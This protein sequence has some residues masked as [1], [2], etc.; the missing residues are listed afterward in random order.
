MAFVALVGASLW[1]V[2]YFFNVHWRSTADSYV[3]PGA[4]ALIAGDLGQIRDGMLVGGVFDDTVDAIADFAAKNGITGVTASATT[5]RAIH[6]HLMDRLATAR[7]RAVVWDYYFR[8]PRPEDTRLAAGVRRLEDAGVPVILAALSFGPDGSPDLS[9]GVVGPLGDRLRQGAIVAR[10]MVKRP[11]EFVMAIKRGEQTVVP[12]VAT[13][14]LASILHPAARVE[15]EWVGRRPSIDLL[16]EVQPGAYMRQRD[17]IEL[18]KVVRMRQAEPPVL[19]DD[20]LAFN[21]FHLER[22]EG[23]QRRTVPYQTLL[24]CPDDELSNLVA[25]KLLVIGDLRSPHL[26]FVGDRHRVKYGVAVVDDVPGCYLLADAIAGSLDRYWVKSAYLLPPTM[27][28]SIM[29]VAVVGC[30]LPI[31]LATAKVFD[32]RWCRRALWIGLFGGSAGSLLLM[33][34]CASYVPV[35]LGIVGF[36]LLMPMAGSC[37]VEFVRNRHR[38]TDRRRHALESFG[39]TPKRTITLASRPGKSLPRA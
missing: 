2:M 34:L 39:L 37:W 20:L 3:S 35:H 28:L 4:S 33:A 5:W 32:R 19:V 24:T 1:V 31:K 8:R 12:S 36:A 18:T 6:G 10:D 9:P 17:R 29:L 14:T 25:G 22:P 27:L 16:Y 13:M 11:G 21:T 7:P 15:F 26:G 38:I 23:W 30:L